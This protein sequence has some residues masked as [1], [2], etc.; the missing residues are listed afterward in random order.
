MDSAVQRVAVSPAEAALML[1][2]SRAAL[3]QLLMS[4]DLRSV[5]VGGRRLVSVAA[6]VALIDGEAAVTEAGAA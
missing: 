6:I 2:I 4:G 3:Y 1:G 5:K